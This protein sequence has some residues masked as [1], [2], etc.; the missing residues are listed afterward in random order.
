MKHI[1]RQVDDP[2]GVLFHS[3]CEHSSVQRHRRVGVQRQHIPTAYSEHNCSV[4][5]AARGMSSTDFSSENTN[6]DYSR[7]CFF[8]KKITW[9][10]NIFCRR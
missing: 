6:T 1:V 10:I 9:R 7:F 5:D 4:L 3:H 2:L 8:L